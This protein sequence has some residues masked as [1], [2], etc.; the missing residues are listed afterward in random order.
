MNKMDENTL[1]LAR[2]H[3]SEYIDGWLCCVWCLVCNYVGVM[4]RRRIVH[5][6]FTCAGPHLIECVFVVGEMIL[7]VS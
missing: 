1:D 2:P 4:I 3:G 7:C 5:V 6:G